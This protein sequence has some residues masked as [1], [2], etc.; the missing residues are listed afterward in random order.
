VGR[1]ALSGR[2]IQSFSAIGRQQTKARRP[3]CRR[4]LGDVGEGRD[5]VAEEHHAEAGE[6]RI[7]R[8]GRKGVGL[9]VG[10]Q[11][12]DVAAVARALAGDLEHGR[13]DVDALD[14]AV[15]A[16][17]L[18]QL[19]TGLPQPQPMSSTRS[20]GC[21]ASASMATRPRGSIWRSS[22]S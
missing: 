7:V 1:A 21:G 13:G 11:E 8:A 6:G 15:G 19:Q 20:P 18:G 2:L 10:F 3:P 22:R 4:A 9:G 5:R 16:D 17:P 14:V 12:V